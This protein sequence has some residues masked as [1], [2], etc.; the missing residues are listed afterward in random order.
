MKRLQTQ[1]FPAAAAGSTLP[2]PDREEIRSA[3]SVLVGPRASRRLLD[4]AGEAGLM[5]WPASHLAAAGRIPRKSAERVVAARELLRRVQGAPRRRV[6]CSADAVA[7]LP[8]E[9]RTSETEVVLAVALSAAVE[10]QAVLVVA[11]GGGSSASLEPRDVFAPL[12][13][14]RAAA[15]VL[16]HNHPSGSV[17]PSRADVLLT[18]RLCAAG[19]IVGIDLV[20][21]VIVAS[22]ATYSFADAGLIPNGADLRGLLDDF[23]CQGG[24]N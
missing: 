20:D 5:R 23:A 14:L 19:R 7:Q 6:S 3:L 13:R 17:L 10:V 1:D 22:D 8:P 21:H 18:N 15:F 9:I 4:S 24:A 2:R 11:L 12:V 16:A